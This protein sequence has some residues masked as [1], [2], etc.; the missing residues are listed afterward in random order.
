MTEKTVA[1]LRCSEVLELL[2]AYL[3]GEL[4]PV[5]VERIEGHLLGCPNCERFG[6]HFGAMVVS[7]HRGPDRPEPVDTRLVSR[8]LSQLDELGMEP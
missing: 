8:L 7:L 1:G 4:E 6:K 2:S 3:D 5:D